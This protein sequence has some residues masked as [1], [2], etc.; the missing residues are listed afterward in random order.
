ML[1][2][3][4]N[5]IWQSLEEGATKR[6]WECDSLIVRFCHDDVG[7]HL[8]LCTAIILDFLNKLAAAKEKVVPDRPSCPWISEAAIK[9]SRPEGARNESK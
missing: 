6:Y 8:H 1:L 7:D 9:A 2:Q 4:R 3:W 5:Q